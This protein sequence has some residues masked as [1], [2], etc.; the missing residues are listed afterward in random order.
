MAE[1]H[2]MWEDGPLREFSEQKPVGDG[3]WIPYFG[4]SLRG[5]V[6]QYVCGGCKMPVVGVY[7]SKCSGKWVCAACLELTNG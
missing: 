3:R 1:I 2:Q 5:F 4:P 6:S 7:S